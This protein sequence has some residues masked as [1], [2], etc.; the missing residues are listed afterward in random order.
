MPLDCVTE[1]RRAAVSGPAC[2]HECVVTHGSVGLTRWQAESIFRGAFPLL[3]WV[4]SFSTGS[5][6]ACDGADVN[7]VLCQTH[8]THETDLQELPSSRAGECFITA[9][10][11]FPLRAASK[12]WRVISGVYSSVKLSSLGCGRVSELMR[13]R[14]AAAVQVRQHLERAVVDSTENSITRKLKHVGELH[15]VL[16]CVFPGW[17]IATRVPSCSCTI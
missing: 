6:R 10:V 16:L 5:R 11:C 12:Q 17:Q 13:R 1:W 14:R 8:E 9:G 4:F 2:P 15:W 3:V 7:N